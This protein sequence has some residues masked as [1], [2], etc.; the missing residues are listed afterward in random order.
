MERAFLACFDLTM[1]P[2]DR[3]GHAVGMSKTDEGKK[4]IETLRKKYMA[5]EFPKYCQYL[6]TWLEASPDR[7]W[8]ATPGDTPTI[9]VCLAVPFLRS[10]TTGYLDHIDPKCLEAHPKLVAYVKRFCALPQFQGRYTTGV[11]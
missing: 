8:L 11:F 3:Y 6:E 7:Q 5:E 1:Y 9:A 2:E 4:V 10:F